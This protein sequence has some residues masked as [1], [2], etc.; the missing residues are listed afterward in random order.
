MITLVYPIFFLT[1]YSLSE[2]IVLTI[3]TTILFTVFSM[4]IYINKNNDVTALNNRF[5]KEI[6][7]LKE[8]NNYISDLFSLIDELQIALIHIDTE[9][10]VINYNQ[11]FDEYF[12][13][14]MNKHYNNISEKKIV[15]IINQV[16]E[17]VIKFDT[18]QIGE[19]YYDIKV[20]LIYKSEEE[21]EIVLQ[22]YDITKL[23]V[24]NKLHQDFLIDASH[25]LNSPLASII[26][27]SEILARDSKSEIIGILIDESSR[28][29][30]VLD[31]IFSHSRLNNIR[32]YPMC[33][34]DLSLM[35][36]SAIV[37]NKRY[38]NV[39]FKIEDNVLLKGNS[40]LI[41]L[42]ITNLLDNAI[43][44]TDKG[45][46]Y[47]KLHSTATN[48]VITVLDEGIGIPKEYIPKIFEKFYRV[49][50]SRSRATGG[51]GLGLAIVKDIV[52]LHD[53]KVN[54]SSDLE[55]GSTFTVYLNKKT[56]EVNQ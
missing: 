14:K 33:E 4:Y 34:F 13:V 5:K 43:K 50:V 41:A 15:D 20:N 18:M 40:D 6:V 51:T 54:V 31:D 45:D 55:V 16:R 39:F 46:V 56:I 8:E 53:G 10:T 23:K 24:L 36:N 1:V 25:E 35:I 3:I 28:M 42:M 11:L 52:R 12:S 30:K 37:K 29:K 26:M 49:D 22:V 47:L 9:D 17:G 44:Y 19:N 27:A 38:N 21:S 2:D 7:D 48:I 32:D